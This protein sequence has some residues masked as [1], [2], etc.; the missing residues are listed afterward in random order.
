MPFDVQMPSHLSC[1]A[2]RRLL[3]L[4]PRAIEVVHLVARAC[5][6]VV[7]DIQIRIPGKGLDAGVAHDK[8]HDP[9]MIAAKSVITEAQVAFA[10]IKRLRRKIAAIAKWL[11]VTDADERIKI[12]IKCRTAFR[13]APS[14]LANKKR[15]AQSIRNALE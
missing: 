12:T 2:T 15:Q 9:R 1:L 10:R 7:E 3:A 4:L 13:S 11:Q 6:G 14:N 5:R 8:Q